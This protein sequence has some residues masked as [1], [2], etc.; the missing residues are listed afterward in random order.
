MAPVGCGI[1]G[2]VT[3]TS[4]RPEPSDYNGDGNTE[5]AIF[6]PSE[7]RVVRERWCDT[8]HDLGQ[9][10]RPAAAAAVRAPLADPARQ[11][12]PRN[13]RLVVLPTD[14]VNAADRWPVSE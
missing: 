9:L 8:V 2:P 6:R 5:I 13:Q 4:D 14:V 10:M 12:L 7:S 3:T 11:Q 1:P